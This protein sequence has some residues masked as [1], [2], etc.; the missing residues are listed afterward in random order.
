MKNLLLFFL[1][2]IAVTGC[3][4]NIIIH[5]PNKAVKTS[6]QVLEAIY[7]EGN[8]REAHNQF[9]TGFQKHYSKENLEQVR[10]MVSSNFGDIKELS[11]DSLMQMPGQRIITLFYI[12]THISTIS[13][14]R[15]ILEGDQ[16][17]YKVSGIFFDNKPYPENKFRRR[18]NKSIIIDKTGVKIIKRNTTK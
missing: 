17:G 3:L 1:T 4:F 13:Y 8:Y 9:T 16:N 12:G 5:D 14:H 10:N 2:C 7:F 15:V 6:T 18:P 11:F